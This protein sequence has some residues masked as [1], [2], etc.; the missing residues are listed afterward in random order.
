MNIF[1]KIISKIKQGNHLVN[2]LDGVL[3]KI[4][5]RI[6][7]LQKEIGRLETRLF[8]FKK[9]ENRLTDYEFKVFSQ[10]GEDG[11]IQF[12]IN[13]IEIPNKMFIEFG[14]EDYTESN[15]RFLLQN[16]NWSGLV[17]DAS[18]KNIERIK[19]DQIYW[20]HNLKAEC[21][22]ID[23][24][25]INDLIKRNGISGD[26]GL[27]SIDIDGNDYWVWE[28]ITCIEPRI[29]I[30]EYDSLLGY[31]KAVVTPY[32]RKFDRKKAHFSYLYGGASVNALYTLGI[33]KG[34]CL[35]GSNSAGNNLFFV[36]NDVIGNLPQVTPEEAYVKAEFRNSRDENGNLSYLGFEESLALIAEM[37]VYDVESHCIIKIRDI[38]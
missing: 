20:K 24:E 27:L 38:G 28:A 18:I 16:N 17:M 30:I 34:Y 5:Y 23:R 32:D 29:L 2:Q 19:K 9:V 1:G 31:K 14:C 22:F 3:Y 21:A 26:I 36:R 15:T 7:N 6:D 37:P 11:I 25:N 8:V 13:N 12:L 4:D 33:R 35:V 10:W